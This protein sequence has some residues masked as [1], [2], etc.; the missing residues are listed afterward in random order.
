M[1]TTTWSGGSHFDYSGSVVTGTEIRYGRDSKN[2]IKISGLQYADLLAHFRGKEVPV[3]TDHVHPPSGS[4]G[5][6]L[7]KNVSETAIASYVAPVLVQ[8]GYAARASD[9]KNI[10][11]NP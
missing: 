10:R 4:L 3:G 2:R 1:T 6:W 5:D 7:K 9:P 8:E 11:F